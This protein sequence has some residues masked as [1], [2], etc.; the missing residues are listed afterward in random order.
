M[1]HAVNHLCS[2]CLVATLL[3]LSGCMSKGIEMTEQQQRMARCDQYIDMAREQC[4]RGENVTIEDY[5][6]EYRAFE[7]DVRDKIKAENEGIQ[8]AS[9]ADEKIKADKLKEAMRKSKELA[10]KAKQDKIDKEIQLI[11]EGTE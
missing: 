8:Q 3:S 11:E 5:K 1:K 2:L 4:L 9:A 6:K 7:K 10:D